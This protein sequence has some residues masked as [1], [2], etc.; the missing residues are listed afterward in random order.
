[1]DL[2]RRG[3]LAAALVCLVVLAGC[4]STLGAPEGQD[5]AGVPPE[6]TTTEGPLNPWDE[7]TL[8]VAVT[9]DL[10]DRDYRAFARSAIEYWNEH[11][12]QAGQADYATPPRLEL[13]DDPDSA[14]VV[15]H[16]QPTIARCDGETANREAGFYT[17]GPTIDANSTVDGQVEYAVTSRFTNTTTTDVTIN[18]LA[19]LYGVDESD[20]PR[21]IESPRLLDPFPRADT[22][23]VGITY[24]ANDDRNVTPL[25]QAAVDYWMANDDT[26]GDYQTDW[27]VDPEAPN[28]D[29]V[30]L[31]V[32]NIV[33]C[34]FGPNQDYYIGCTNLLGTDTSANTPVQVEIA[35]GYTDNSTI[36]TIKHEFGHLYGRE[37]GE[38]PM[39]LMSATGDAVPRNETTTE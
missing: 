25:V 16:Y 34:G 29:V 24:I 7:E 39:P 1:M 15:L 11:R 36:T 5:P 23:T 19:G 33:A 6:T 28:P 21:A 8:T 17:C 18:A 37:H 13:T 31:Y 38:G 27:V 22:V 2:D 10:Q 3:L 35:A 32:D 9:A 14:D 26:Y 4:Q 30:V 20:E 12:I